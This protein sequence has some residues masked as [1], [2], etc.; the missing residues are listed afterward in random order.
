MQAGRG[1]LERAAILDVQVLLHYNTMISVSREAY[2]RAPAKSREAADENDPSKRADIS[3]K[4]KQYWAGQSVH[5]YNSY[6]LLPAR[7]AEEWRSGNRAHTASL[8]PYPHLAYAVHSIT[9][10]MYA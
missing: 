1:R 5:Y 2:T 10:R 9:K 4:K 8:R 3:R 7:V 6:K